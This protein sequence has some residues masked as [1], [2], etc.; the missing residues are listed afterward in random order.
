MLDAKAVQIR[1]DGRVVNLAAVIAVGVRE[2]G[3]REVLGFAVGAAEPYEF[4]L[5]SLRGLVARGLRGCGWPS[6]QRP[7]GAEAGRR[8]GVGGG[9][10]VLPRGEGCRGHVLGTRRARVPRHL[11][12]RAAALVRT[13]VA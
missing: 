3:Q 6:L 1:Q 10:L 2:T 12:L 11:Q 8:R 13:S 4:W 5:A 7:P 9:D